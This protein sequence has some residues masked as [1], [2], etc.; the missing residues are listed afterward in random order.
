MKYCS[1]PMLSASNKTLLMEREG[2]KV[3]DDF[4]HEQNLLLLCE[5]KKVLLAGCAHRGIANILNCAEKI[6]GGEMDLVIGGFHLG[7]PGTGKTEP[8]E[9]IDKYQ[10]FCS[11]ARI[12]AI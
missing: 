11:R 3:Q 1:L 10:N 7:N 5:G 8:V 2:E 12:R 6:A 9:L 4:T